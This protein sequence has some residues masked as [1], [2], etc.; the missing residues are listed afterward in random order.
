M[1]APSHLPNAPIAEAV[2]DLRVSF[3][4]PPAVEAH[5][6]IAEKMGGYVETGKI[7]NVVAVMLADPAAAPAQISTPQQIGARYTSADGLYVMQSRADGLTLSRLKPYQE[8]EPLFNEMWRAWTAYKE[9]LKPTGVVRVSARFINQIDLPA[10][11]DLDEYFVVSPKLPEGAPNFM[12]TFSSVVGIPFEEQKA[13]AF[14]RMAMPIS[15]DPTKCPVVLDFDILRDCDLGPDDDDDVRANINSLRS[16]K[17]R[18]FFGS[19]TEKCVGLF[20]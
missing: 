3:A 11:S 9:V 10:G 12:T 18:L 17:N 16:I 13:I 2:L 19:I 7:Q 4:A 1:V 6:Q 15:P 14:M 5:A 8:W 20:Q